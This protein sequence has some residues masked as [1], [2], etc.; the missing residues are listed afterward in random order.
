MTN[1]VRH[2]TL[3]LALG[4]VVPLGAEANDFLLYAPRPAETPAVPKPAEGVLVERITIQRGDTLYRLSRKFSGKGS[5]YPQILLFNEIANPNRIYAGR[6]LLVPVSS[7]SLPAAP[8]A[9]K[10]KDARPSAAGKRKGTAKAA[11][12]APTVTK[13]EQPV[14]A[15][16]AAPLT[17]EQGLYARAIG[18]YRKGE[19][20]QALEAFSLF[21]EQ[22]PNSPLAP[23]AALYKAE[24]LLKLA[25]E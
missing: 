18:E 23:D 24:C 19:Y 17:A 20:Q 13:A 22:Y 8:A 15:A 7:A 21:V 6:S 25:G 14:A 2:W 4:M 11:V 10:K 3:A 1:F 5:Y 12:A 9:E 16:A